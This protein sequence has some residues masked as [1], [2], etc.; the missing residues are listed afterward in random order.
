MNTTRHALFLPVSREAKF[1]GKTA[2]D[3][4]F[5]RMGDLIQA[6]VIFA[7]M[8]WFAVDAFD[9]AT[10]NLLLALG[11]I[12]LAYGIG[13]R[14]ATLAKTTVLN[15]APEVR[16]GIPDLSLPPGDVVRCH[17]DIDTFADADPGDVLALRAQQ[18]DGS[19]LPP[20]L[21]FDPERR[22]FAG[23]VPDQPGREWWI[24]LIA[25][26]V[27]GSEVRLR[28]VIRCDPAA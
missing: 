9:F 6:A 10:L 3:T 23:V 1:D 28:F 15:V 21:I 19:P 25:S 8:R 11:W 12:A 4:F 5:W 24:E 22:R 20:W 26:D 27:D 13:R 18:A 14:Y 7:G 17:I 16:H 2:I